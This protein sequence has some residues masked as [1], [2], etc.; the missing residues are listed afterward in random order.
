MSLKVLFP[1]L[2]SGLPV[3]IDGLLVV[4]LSWQE[5][6]V[7]SVLPLGRQLW[8]LAAW[9]WVRMEEVGHSI[10]KFLFVRH[11]I[12]SFNPQRNLWGGCYC[13]LHFTDQETETLM[14]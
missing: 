14:C 13:Y 8:A 11:C 2:A 6:G 10:E 9:V 3:C 1:D 12:N 7:D 4:R 5:N